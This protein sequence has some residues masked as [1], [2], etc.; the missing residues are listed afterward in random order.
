MQATERVLVVYMVRVGVSHHWRRLSR[1]VTHADLASQLSA[2]RRNRPR[3][4]Q[5]RIELSSGRAA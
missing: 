2:L 3:I 5:G 4:S 1:H